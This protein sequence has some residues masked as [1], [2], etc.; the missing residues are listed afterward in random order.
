MS[1][2]REESLRA[3][4]SR[5]GWG[6]AALMPLPGDASTRRYL[7]ALKGER[8][9]M[10]MDQPLGAES[11]PCP[12]EASEETRRA[13]GYN[14][15]AR[16]AGADCARFV[17]VAE[18]LRGRGLSAPEIYAAEPEHG[19]VLME[20]LG[21][22]LYAD[23]LLAGADEAQLYRSAAEALARLH[24]AP[25]PVM[26]SPEKPLYAYDETAMLAEIDLMTEW[27]FPVG[28]S[29][30]A[31]EDEVAEHRALW[32]E[33]LRPVLEAEAVFVHRD[34]HAQNLLWLSERREAA[35]VGLIDFQDAVAGSRAYDLI[36]LTEDARRDVAPE[37]AEA[38]TG[39][40]L[41]AMRRQGT[42]RDE[43][44]HRAEMAVAAAQRN[45]KIV[46]IFARLYKRD[47]KPRY[48]S[49]LPRV[50]GYLNRDLE[51]PA[52]APLKAWYDTK[53]PPECRGEPRLEG[54]NA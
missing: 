33:V 12:P 32:R 34:Y 17:A 40:Y 29:R 2:E 31:H 5:A 51:H 35:R 43:E 46:G 16:L 24:A 8:V 45:A 13:L 49:Y 9:A 6:E 53:V 7:R 3:F 37:L 20:D 44:T 18:F 39:A 1:A 21:E 4:L 19:F 41:A 52:L 26:L 28:L 42:P 23:V 11:P 30:P 14:A 54:M 47:G 15:V 38:T 50:W 27:F 36:S 10:L 22:R 48:L 25:A